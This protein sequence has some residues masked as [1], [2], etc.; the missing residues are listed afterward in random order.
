[1]INENTIEAVY[2]LAELMAKKGIAVT[3]MPTT[4]VETL[5]RAGHL[6]RQRP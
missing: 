2:P 3:P 6:P 4:P 1:M 5:V